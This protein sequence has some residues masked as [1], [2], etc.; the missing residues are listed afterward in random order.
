[1]IIRKNLTLFLKVSFL[2]EHKLYSALPLTR[3]NF[4]YA[5]GMKTTLTL[6]LSLISL[7]TFASELRP[8]KFIPLKASTVVV[9]SPSSELTRDP[10][11]KQRIVKIEKD[12]EIQETELTQHQWF[13]VTGANP[14]GDIYFCESISIDGVP[15][16]AN[17][18]VNRVSWNN[19]QSFLKKLNAKNDGYL[20][21]LPTEAEWEYAARAGS[22][23]AFSFGDLIEKEYSQGDS[24]SY[25]AKGAKHHT[26]FAE[27][28]Q[29]DSEV[30]GKLKPNAFGLYDMHGNVAEWVQEKVIK[31]GAWDDFIQDQRVAHRK[32]KK[33][34]ELDYALGFRLVRLKN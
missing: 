19:I 14:S 15:L 8:M 6:C 1:M 3:R 4:R 30:V 10:H 23:T 29:A 5:P 2:K 28:S 27:N 32:L 33:A 34:H 21:R 7:T 11:E 22:K 13:K 25:E 17:R 9:G 24:Y 20:Y 18:P 12:F 31:G 26:W 16:C